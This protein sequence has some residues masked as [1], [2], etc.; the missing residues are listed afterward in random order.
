MEERL[1]QRQINN[2]TLD[3]YYPRKY[4]LNVS[5]FYIFLKK[6]SIQQI[7]LA[8]PHTM[9]STSP[10]YVTS[11][12]TGVTMSHPSQLATFP[13]PTL[14]ANNPA[15]NLINGS[16]SA[17]GCGASANGSYPAETVNYIPNFFPFVFL[18][19]IS[20]RYVYIYYVHPHIRLYVLQ[21][22]AKHSHIIVKTYVRTIYQCRH[23]FFLVSR[24]DLLE[25][26]SASD[27]KTITLNC[28]VGCKFKEYLS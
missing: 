27:Q 5:I 16:R 28:R 4:S 21:Y 8:H 25:M 26:S 15:N 13:P 1:H 22:H 11:S 19:S 2:Y 12:A 14:F 17:S 6:N 7:D 3:K 23:F 9:Y 24:N 10:M 20:H 18:F